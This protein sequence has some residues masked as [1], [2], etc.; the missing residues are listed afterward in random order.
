MFATPEGHLE[1][2]EYLRPVRT[3]KD[4]KWVDVDTD[5]A[6]SSA[7]VRPKAAVTDVT[8][9]AG[10]DQPLVRMERAGRE[11]ALSWPSAL[12]QPVVSGDTATYPEVLPGVDL[13][14][15]AQV[16]G[17]TQLLVGKSA[18]AAANPELKSLRLK[19][20]AEGMAV[21]ETAQ[22]GLEAVDDGAGSAVFEAPTPQMWDSSTGPGAGS[23]A[24]GAS[25]AARS[26]GSVNAVAEGADE[27]GAAESGK[28]APVGVDVPA[29]GRELVLTPDKD[30][31]AGKDTQYPVFIDPQWYSPRASSWT[32]ASKYW[33][34]SPQWKFNGK[35]DA[36][37]GFCGWDY[38]A[39]QDTK[40]VLYQIPVSKFAGKSILSAEFVV[41]NTWS[42]T[43]SNH[44]VELWQT[45][46]ISSST[47]WNSQN[48]SGFWVKK[49]DTRSFAYGFNGKDQKDAEFD[50][51]SA[52]QS[53]ANSKASTM[54]FGLRASDESDKNAWK[55]FSDKAYLR[56][57]YNRP[58]AQVRTSQLSME[59]GGSCKNSASAARVRTLGKLYANNVTDPD[60]DSVAVQFQASWGA[61][62]KPQWKP[63]R[64]TLKPSGSSFVLPLPSSIPKNTKVN[65]YVRVWDGAQ[66]SPW[67]YAGDPQACY[68]TYDTSVPKAPSLSSGEYPEINPEDPQ[69]PWYD[70]VGKY[71]SFSLKA[72]DADV[73]TYWY[74]INSDPSSSHKITTSAGAAKT[75]QT[76]PSKP[77]LNYV[78][79]QA[80]DAAG[81]GSEIR[82]YIFRVRAGQPDRATWQLD[83]AAG[84][85][86]AKGSTPARTMDV[87]GGVTLGEEGAIGTAAHFNGTDGYAYSDLPVVNTSGGFA[88]SAWVKLD[89]MPEQAAVVA[90][91]TGNNKPGFELYYSS[92]YD[93]WV[94]N[95]YSEDKAGTIPIVRAMSAQPGDAKAG[96]WTHLVGSYSSTD[97]KLALYVDGKLAGETAYSTPWEA[98]R[99]FQIG[100]GSYTGDGR[101][102]FFPGL[103]DEVQVF[104]KPLT[105]NEVAVLKDKKDVGD[106]G[107]PAVAQ[108]PLDEAAGATKVEG[109]GQVFPAK[110]SGGVS[111][112]AVAQFPLDEAAGATKVEGHGQVFPAKYSGGVTTGVE[113]VTGKAAHFDGKTGY[114][115]IAQSR[116]PHMNTQRSFAV[117]AWAKLDKK[118]DAAADIVLQAGNFAPGLELYYSS[119]YDRWAFNQYSEDAVG[120]KVIRAMQPD[121]AHA[122]VG[123]WAHLVG[124]HDTVANTLTLYV[125]GA[126]AGTTDLPEAWYADQSMYLGAG[127]YNGSTAPS[128]YFPG[129]IDDVRL[130]DRVVSPE[131]VAQMFKQHPLLKGR[132]NFEEK[133]ESTPATSPD[134][135]AQGRAMTLQ[136]G[137]DLG[138]GWVD[139]KGLDLN[140]TDAYASTS[141]M[142][143]DTGTSFSLSAWTLAAAQPDKEVTVR[144]AEAST[145]TAV[146]VN[147]VPGTDT[148]LQGRF[149]LSVASKDG[150][151][152]TV[153]KVS[154]TSFDDIT[155]PNHLAVVYD[156]FA[157]EV[158]LYVNGQLQESVCGDDDGDDKADDSTCQDV[159]A[160]SENVL[161]HKAARGFDVGAAVTGGKAGNFFPGMIDDVWAFQGAL[162]ENQVQYLNTSLYDVPTQV[163]GSA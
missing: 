154:S 53:A 10:G 123:E 82:T 113:G 58:P 28:L 19:R 54:T 12:P 93:W 132:W 33:A 8:F 14:L 18:E 87:H 151:D 26:G 75:F 108:F 77:G 106:P 150:A 142:P 11:L 155:G 136:G 111:R 112:P 39:P 110:Y 79:A 120:A 4:G 21:K 149:E 156:G 107:R 85:T 70:G 81:N 99:G 147:W 134:L 30:V 6:V 102:A 51:K 34:S 127:V 152:A 2:R 100:A 145:N 59:Y 104:D 25:K 103:I 16:D 88:V 94:F 13:R 76:L 31:L 163:P 138:F 40:R 126:K 66:Y 24:G 128:S 69:D 129:T 1:A 74:G 35:H 90:S 50:V 49:L 46:G 22:G 124:V 43:S 95:Q 109:H 131:E 65:W 23:S 67:S 91:Q 38:C 157:K 135:S 7:G 72:A 159:I 137:A 37:V 114:A 148:N 121:G 162:D 115:R 118:P 60:G 140:G 42:A 119:A 141:A 15:G 78:S 61:D 92:S 44:S 133:S 45:K 146:R 47:T 32:M 56:V 122:Q 97:D 36:G 57:Q 64:T 27:P 20:A 5:L 62:N 144:N 71:G 55:R 116:G 143:V 73:T 83:E 117:S 98:R 158:R 101:S 17:F 86:E 29:G 89:K 105:V 3:R 68:F 96:S 125:N 41:R 139:D 63:A 52:V 130:Y 153:E 84:E 160:W 161:T 48:A 80:F 9:S